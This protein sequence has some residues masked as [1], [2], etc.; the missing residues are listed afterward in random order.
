MSERMS[1]ENH[2]GY[3]E[4]LQQRAPPQVSEIQRDS[5]QSIYV[6]GLPNEPESNPQPPSPGQPQPKTQMMSEFAQPVDQ[7]YEALKAKDRIIAQLQEERRELETELGEWR[8]RYIPMK[9]V[10]KPTIQAKA[11]ET[12]QIAGVLIVA[13]FLGYFLG[14]K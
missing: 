9:V 3:A 2:P 6:S 12:W 10:Q 5:I 8:A 11:F 1:F 4:A 13:I 7:S 14:T